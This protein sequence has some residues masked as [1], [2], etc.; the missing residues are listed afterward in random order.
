[1]AHMLVGEVFLGILPMV[2]GIEVH[3]IE[4]ARIQDTLTQDSECFLHQTF[5]IDEQLYCLAHRVPARH[6]AARLA[7][8]EAVLKIL[9]IAQRV[10][11]IWTDIAIGASSSG[12]PY[13]TLEG[14]LREKAHQLAITQWHLSL[15]HTSQYAGAFVV[16]ESMSNTVGSAANTR[17][18]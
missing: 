17:K 8:K 6:L 14:R 12:S 5:T 13:L 1:M 7:A 10:G 11:F 3:M 9:G 16:A 15:T 4:I 2:I 18:L